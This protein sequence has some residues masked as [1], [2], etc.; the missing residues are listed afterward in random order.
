[1]R[2]LPQALEIIFEVQRKRSIEKIARRKISFSTYKTPFFFFFSFLLFR[3]RL[4]SKLLTFSF[5][6]HLKLFKLL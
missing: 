2:A 1:M 6:V 3:P 5:L 4:F